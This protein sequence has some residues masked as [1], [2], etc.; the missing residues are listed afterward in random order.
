MDAAGF[1]VIGL[2]YVDWVLFTL[3]VCVIYIGKKTIDKRF[4][5][6]DG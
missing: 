6:M 3:W 1:S 5:D 2:S 4:E